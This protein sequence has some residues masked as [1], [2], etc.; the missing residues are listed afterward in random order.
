M[1]IRDGRTIA[2]LAGLGV[3]CVAGLGWGWR[4]ELR[5]WYVGYRFIWL[6]DG[7]IPESINAAG[8]AAVNRGLERLQTEAGRWALDQRSFLPLGT[9]PH[10]DPRTRATAISDQG[11]IIG[12]VHRGG[13]HLARAFLWTPDDGLREIEKLGGQQIA[14]IDLNSRNQVVGWSHPPGR[15][16]PW[17]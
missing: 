17:R 16:V 1:K 10:G 12:S 3:L 14:P 9:L 11:S 4:E 8:E 13:D 6:E 5:A 15:G 7:L 2:L